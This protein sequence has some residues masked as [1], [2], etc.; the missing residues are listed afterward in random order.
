MISIKISKKFIGNFSCNNNTNIEIN[1]DECNNEKYY[2]LLA[3]NNQKYSSEKD[4]FSLCRHP[5]FI[6]HCVLNINNFVFDKIYSSYNNIWDLLNN[7]KTYFDDNKQLF[8]LNRYQ[9]YTKYLLNFNVNFMNREKLIVYN[10]NF[11]VNKLQD[12][13]IDF[14]LYLICLELD[15]LNILRTNMIANNIKHYNDM[16]DTYKKEYDNFNII[17]KL[18]YNIKSTKRLYNKLFLTKNKNNKSTIRKI[19]ALCEK[20]AYNEKEKIYLEY[21]DVL[22]LDINI[23]IF[24]KPN[25]NFE[26]YD[27]KKFLFENDIRDFVVNMSCGKD[28][29]NI[30][31]SNCNINNFKKNKKLFENELEIFSNL[32]QK[33]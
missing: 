33:F 25:K 5:E 1:E 15:E 32:K 12:I 4:N 18:K 8:I 22:N 20:I 21:Y 23:N 10:K 17:K 11:D 16:Q 26:Y 29:A 24:D 31:I 30:N 19:K 7:Q 2:I 28:I 14:D 27:K 9:L 3:E 13:N 6:S